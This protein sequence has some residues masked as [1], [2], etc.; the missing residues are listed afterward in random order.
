MASDTEKN[1]QDGIKEKLA[2]FFEKIGGLSKVQRLLICVL[3]ILVMGGSYYYFIFAPKNKMLQSA[4]TEYKNQV[5]KLDTFKR[6][7]RALK[8]FETKMAKVQEEFNMAMKAL[9]EKKELPSLLRGVSTAGS[10]AGLVFLLFQPAPVVN[11]EFYKEIPMSLKVEGSFHQIADFFF[12]V[13]NLNRIVNIDNMSMVTEKKEAGLI[14]MDCSA[15]TYMFAEPQE[16][17]TSDKKKNP[18]GK[19]KG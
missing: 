17:K 13:G 7:A 5:V 9:P 11:K 2:S 8:E 3:T 18:R 16:E 1:K 14:Q 19:K 15:V 10:N 4:K 12:Q 6:K